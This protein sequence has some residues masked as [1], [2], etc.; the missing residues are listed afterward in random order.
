MCLASQ[1]WIQ[2]DSDPAL[3]LRYHKEHN[4][5][6]KASVDPWA[7]DWELSAP[8]STRERT[9]RYRT[10]LAAPDWLKKC[11]LGGSISPLSRLAHRGQGASRECCHDP[12]IA[13]CTGGLPSVAVVDTQQVCVSNGACTAASEAHHLPARR[14]ALCIRNIGVGDAQCN[15]S[16][17]LPQSPGMGLVLAC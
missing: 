10:Q 12:V 14:A 6:E 17:R 13:A 2:I 9:M 1:D 15:S 8:V 4:R 5:D 16:V 7:P 11:L 3:W